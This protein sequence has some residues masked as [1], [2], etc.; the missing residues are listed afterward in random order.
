M[1]LPNGA[2]EELWVV[3]VD[4][5]LELSGRIGSTIESEGQL[6]RQANVFDHLQ[7]LLQERL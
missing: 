2:L 5:G 1:G 3:S 4:K 7:A 6:A